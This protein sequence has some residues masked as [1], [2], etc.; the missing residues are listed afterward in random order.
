MLYPQPCRGDFG[1]TLTQEVK[2]ACTMDLV[3]HLLLL[4]SPRKKTLLKNK[5]YVICPVYSGSTLHL[6]PR[7][8]E[9]LHPLQTNNMQS[10]QR[11]SIKVFWLISHIDIVDTPVD[12]AVGG[13]GG[14]FCLL[15]LSNNQKQTLLPR[16]NLFI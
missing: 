10:F 6:P 12:I 2:P 5:H 16:I 8:N 13:G 4:Q 14:V 3:S 1:R 11:K 15:N 9:G 7:P